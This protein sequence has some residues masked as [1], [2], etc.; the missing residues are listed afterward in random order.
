MNHVVHTEID[1]DAPPA[2]VFALLADTAGWTSWGT[3][4]EAELVEPAPGDQPEGVGAVRRFRLGRTTSVERVVAFE[5]DRR[6]AYDLVSG[7][8]IRGYHA[9]V[10]LTERPGGGT[11][12]VWH[13][14]FRGRM[15]NGWIVRRVLQRFIDD[16]AAR[17]ATAAEVR[18]RTDA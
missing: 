17:M 4:D 8:P 14:E 13:S 11:H 2:T 6:L 10:T 12:L 7:I 5:P 9:E 16:T 3:H 18:A 1:V 15:G